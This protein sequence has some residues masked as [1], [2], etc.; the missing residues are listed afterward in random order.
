MTEER[1]QQPDWEDRGLLKEMLSELADRP[2]LVD[3]A[4]CL[5]LRDQLRAAAAG[6]AFLLQAG[7]C[8]ERFAE[9][10]P[11]RVRPKASLLHGLADH[12]EDATGRQVIWVGRL[13]GQFAKPR[14]CATE[15]LPDGS[16]VPT[17]RGDAVNDVPPTPQARKPDPRRLLQAYDCAARAIDALPAN[18]WPV[19]SGTSP[20]ATRRAP[21]Y[22]SHEALLLEYEQALV[23]E[24]PDFVNSVY[25]S[26][27]HLLWIG[28]RTRQADGAHVRFAAMVDNPVAVKVG[29]SAS[30]GEVREFVARLTDGYPLGRLVLISRM[31]AGRVTDRLRAVLH[32]LGDLA[33]QVVWSCDP[34]HGNTVTNRHR[35][36][37]RV[38]DDML[39]EVDGFV[40]VLNEHD[41]R[42]GGLHLEVAPDP[43]TECLDTPRELARDRMLPRYESACDPRLSPPQADRVVTHTAQLLGTTR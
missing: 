21:T 8:A 30:P 41:L 7:D 40:S 12:L 11:D 37:V 33:G 35:Q 27:A 13:A 15:A 38:V 10:V 34:M 25:A 20:L 4:S 5:S 24:R 22:I 32:A 26:S 42:P 1:V 17:Y 3:A 6:Q 18:G 36:K 2:P 9:C 43:V 19:P 28:D 39:R 29:P 23:R 14:S 16:V 31:G